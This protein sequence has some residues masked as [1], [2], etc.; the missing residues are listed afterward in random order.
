MACAYRAASDFA[1]ST[2]MIADESAMTLEG[3]NVL[4]RLVFEW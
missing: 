3:R 2:A 1:Q 4:W